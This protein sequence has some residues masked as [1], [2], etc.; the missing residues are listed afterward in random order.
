MKIRSIYVIIGLALS[1]SIF[2]GILWS[3]EHDPFPI[4]DPPIVVNPDNSYGGS[5]VDCNYV[6]VC[7]ESSVLPI[8]VSACAK[9]GCHDAIK[10]EAGFNLSSYA[11]IIR[12]GIVP[13]NANESDLY[14]VTKQTG[15]DRMPPFPD[16]PLTIAQKDSIA[17][18]INEGAKNTVKC[19][20]SC[21]STQYTYTATIAP[22]LANYCVGCH[23]P[24]SLG[25]NIDLS[26]YNGVKA[27][28]TS[29]RLEGSV[30]H[31]PGF[32]AMPKG[33]KLSDCQIT[34]ISKWIA[35]GATNN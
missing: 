33:S 1:I 2:T 12:K 25:G 11:N 22:L 3:C 26:S 18:W 10:R 30:R 13:G 16:S 8:F 20:C 34:Q 27:A 4:P 24:N 35:S 15:E 29:N 32:S 31:S 28:V 7:F 23:S 14:K 17:K 21:D 6:G 19:N 9:S 5:G